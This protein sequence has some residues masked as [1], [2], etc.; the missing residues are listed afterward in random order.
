VNADTASCK[1]VIVD[2]TVDNSPRYLVACADAARRKKRRGLAHRSLRLREE[3]T[4]YPVEVVNLG[5]TSKWHNL[6]G[7]AIRLG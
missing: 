1:T 5:G 6:I 2:M 3:R 4:R 7:R